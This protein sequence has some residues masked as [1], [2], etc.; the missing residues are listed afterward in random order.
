MCVCVCLSVCLSVS[1]LTAEPSGGGGPNRVCR[2]IGGGVGS[3]KFKNG[4]CRSRGA[5]RVGGSIFYHY[6]YREVLY[7]QC[8]VYNGSI[9]LD[10]LYF[11]QL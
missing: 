11:F 2:F 4:R 3:V 5:P 1:A 10:D 8:N 6:R 7:G 9:F